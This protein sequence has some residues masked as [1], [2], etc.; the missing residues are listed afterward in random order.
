MLHSEDQSWGDLFT[1]SDCIVSR[2]R[3]LAVDVKVNW[4]GSPTWFSANSFLREGL[5]EAWQGWVESR[6]RGLVKRLEWRKSGHDRWRQ[7]LRRLRILPGKIVLS[8]GQISGCRWL[9]GFDHGPLGRV[10]EEE[11]ISKVFQQFAVQ[12][13]LDAHSKGVWVDCASRCLSSVFGPNKD[14]LGGLPFQIEYELLAPMC[15]LKM[16]YVSPCDVLPESMLEHLGGRKAATAKWE[17]YKATRKQLMLSPFGPQLRAMRPAQENIPP[18]QA[19]AGELNL[20]QLADHAAAKAARARPLAVLD[21][22]QIAR[23]VSFD[24]RTRAA[25]DT[26]GAPR[27]SAR[28]IVVALEFLLARGLE[29]DVVLPVRAYHGWHTQ[30]TPGESHTSDGKLDECELLEPYIKGRQVHLSPTGQND[31]RFI[32]QVALEKGAS[33][34][35]TNDLYRDHCEGHARCKEKGDAMV[36]EQW[37][38]DH[39]FGYLFVGDKLFLQK[40][41]HAR[42]S[43]V[44]SAISL[45]SML[46]GEELQADVPPRPKP[47]VIDG[48]DLSLHACFFQPWSGMAATPNGNARPLVTAIEYFTLRGHPV[49]CVLSQSAYCGY[50]PDRSDATETRPG[51][52]QV[53]QSRPPISDWQLLEPHLRRHVHLAPSGFD[54][55]SFIVDVAQEMGAM[56][57]S[58]NFGP[59][60]HRCTRSWLQTHQLRYRMV[61]GKLRVSPWPAF[62]TNS[63]RTTWQTAQSKRSKHNAL[64]D[65]D[66]SKHDDSKRRRISLNDDRGQRSELPLAVAGR[67]GIPTLHNTEHMLEVQQVSL[68][69]PVKASVA[70]RY[71]SNTVMRAEP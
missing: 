44:T 5:L 37:L 7:Q 41:S 31:D 69:V 22:M 51:A 50:E 53:S 58:N 25:D 46:V 71:Y 29:V 26:S 45:G 68:S 47:V 49:H 6:L 61:Q 17:Q 18:G 10:T 13:R 8:D 15:E 57:L 66:A 34:V 2:E 67:P 27:G 52:A 55:D 65:Q 62:A 23:T 56:I 20:L 14:V 12:A 38:V 36:N 48:R 9:I 63:T 59:I 16:E 4:Q 43:T 54:C 33:M 40:R 3:F 42:S 24:C 30:E 11:H 70:D 60:E 1:A 35:L 64:A 39:C 19:S 32:L 21:G 28:A